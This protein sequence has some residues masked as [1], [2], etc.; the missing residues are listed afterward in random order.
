MMAERVA[1]SS[2]AAPSELLSRSGG[3]I[4][5]EQLSRSTQCVD[6]F[7]KTDFRK[8]LSSFTVPT[9]IIHG[10]YKTDPIDTSGRA[11]AKGIA[12]AKFIEYDGEPHGLFSAVPDKLNADVKIFIG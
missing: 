9:L 1:L 8:D 5:G 4:W 6:A 11:A 3:G 10:R 7:G 2:V 12:G